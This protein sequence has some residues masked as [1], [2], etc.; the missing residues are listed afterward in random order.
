V[1]RLT[2]KLLFTLFA[3]GLSLPA[4]AATEVGEVA[5][6]RGVLTGQ[7]D[8]EPPR[9]IARGVA[10]HNGETLNTGSK[11]F[12]I[13][14][15]EDG[16]RMTLRPNTTF[17]IEEVSQERGSENAL[18]S[19]IRGGLR[20]ITG[21]ISKRNPNAFRINTSVAT[22][23]IR[24]TEFDARLCATTECQAEEDASGRQ[25]ERDSR[26][27]GRIALLNGRASAQE[28]GRPGR[29]LSV[30]AAVYERDQIQTAERSFTVIAFNDKTRVT[31]SPQ[32]AFRIEEHEYTPE[33]PGDN[34][35]FMRF[36]R[37]GMRLVSGLIGQLN[38]QA[39]R[40]GTPT[41]TIG[42]RGTGFDL[43]CQGACVDENAL[44]DPVGETLIGQ[45][46]NLFVRPVYAQ[47]ATSGMYA[48]AW[49]GSILLH[50]D[51]GSALLPTGRTAFV[52]NSSSRPRVVA[53]IPPLLRNFQG[54]PRPDRVDVPAEFFSEVEPAAIEPGLYVRVDSG[55]VAVQGFDGK[56]VHIGAG[57]ALH[58]GL[59]RTER[60]GI[61]PAFQK[62]DRFPKP[63]RLNNRSETMMDL[64]GE[65]GA[66]TEALECTVR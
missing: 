53:D 27:I 44:R 29:E 19:L 18:L 58:A 3:L 38:P 59:D 31:L 52:R 30:G 14:E 6:S 35:S 24:G 21:A 2:D 22:I 66:E 23:G 43:V 48:K 26:V 64:L 9:L 17:K 51:G 34:N 56:V 55:D 46:L 13:I 63:S 61:V 60:L 57:E 11:G 25:G 54:A 49:Q 7:I 4:P 40:V 41:V 12:A 15:L 10:L 50:L 65:R 62:F 37:G 47:A 1:T 32:S 5:Y 8:G 39:V 20:A 33:Q 45:F 36:L 16:T 42:I 28:D